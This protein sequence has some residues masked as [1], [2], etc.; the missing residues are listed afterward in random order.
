MLTCV[1]VLYSVSQGH[2][3]LTFCFIAMFLFL[4]CFFFQ[5]SFVLPLI[6]KLKLKN[7]SHKRGRAPVVGIKDLS[8]YYF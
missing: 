5:L 1:A 8:S 6:E 2:L 3:P 7:L 4:F